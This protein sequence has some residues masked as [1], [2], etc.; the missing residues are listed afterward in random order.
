[1][2]KL[3]NIHCNNHVSNKFPFTD[4][5]FNS[6]QCTCILSSHLQIILN[7]YIGNLNI[8]QTCGRKTPYYDACWFSSCATDL[9]VQSWGFDMSK[10]SNW[11][12]TSISYLLWQKIKWEC[13]IRR[14][15]QYACVVCGVCLQDGSHS[16]KT[17]ELC[18]VQR[19]WDSLSERNPNWE[20]QHQQY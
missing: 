2:S 20:M 13:A 15:Q 3:C 9:W 16:F 17:S 12:R 5:K 7:N 11:S 10:F 14:A 8:T 18:R 6:I 1:M 4:N 19:S